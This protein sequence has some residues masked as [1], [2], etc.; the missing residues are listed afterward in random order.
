M[1]KVDEAF[2]KWE[3]ENFSHLNYEI[4]IEDAT[5]IVLNFCKEYNT[6]I[7][8]SFRKKKAAHGTY[9]EPSLTPSGINPAR[10]ILSKPP[11]FLTTLHECAHHLTFLD[12]GSSNGHNNKFIITMIKIAEEYK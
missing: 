6:T 1:K 8:L 7:E 2:Y 4:S 10:I 5:E 12:Y 9:Y 11:N 3:N